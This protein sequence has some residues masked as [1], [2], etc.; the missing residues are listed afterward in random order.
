MS[1]DALRAK[2]AAMS[3]A[4]A[5]PV[6][7]R[8]WIGGAWFWIVIGFF[9]VAGL[10][11]HWITQ[12]R[13]ERAALRETIA[14]MLHSDRASLARMWHVRVFKP[15]HFKTEY[16]DR[17]TWIPNAHAPSAMAITPRSATNESDA[18]YLLYYGETPQLLFALTSA[19]VF[20]NEQQV[21][22]RRY[23]RTYLPRPLSPTELER[24]GELLQFI[25]ERRDRYNPQSQQ[26]IWT[27]QVLKTALEIKMAQQAIGSPAAKYKFSLSSLSRLRDGI[28]G[29]PGP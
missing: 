27:D 20:V 4:R 2:K 5:L 23:P 12:T 3:S 1:V 16:A 14:R 26:Y 24:L 7:H 22:L 9:C 17:I 11:A 29:R 13:H 8:R 28:Q 15:Y 18:I 10:L 19:G 6:R 25:K 21:D